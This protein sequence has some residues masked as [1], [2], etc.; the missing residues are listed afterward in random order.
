MNEKASEVEKHVQFIKEG[1]SFS[2]DDVDD[3]RRSISTTCL[4]N[5][6]TAECVR[7]CTRDYN[8]GGV[9]RVGYFENMRDES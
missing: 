9:L 7:L 6:E 8:E 1:S 5:H 4:A 3:D 2:G